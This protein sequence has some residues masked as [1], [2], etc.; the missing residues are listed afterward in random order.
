LRNLKG[1]KQKAEKLVKSH[2]SNASHQKAAVSHKKASTNDTD[3]QDNC[4][5]DSFDMSKDNMYARQKKLNQ[6][7]SF[8]FNAYNKQKNIIGIQTHATCT[9]NYH[10]LTNPNNNANT[11]SGYVAY[12]DASYYQGNSF[13]YQQNYYASPN[14]NYDT[15]NYQGLSTDSD[16]N[17]QDNYMNQYY[18]YDGE[19]Y[20]KN[21]M[22]QNYMPVDGQYNFD[23]QQQNM[24]YYNESA[25]GQGY[26]QYPEYANPSY[27]YDNYQPDY[28]NYG[29][30]SMYQNFQDLEQH[31][32]QSYNNDSCY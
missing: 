19:F 18:N 5:V 4:S 22:S 26:Y 17:Q 14:Q 12:P 9:S 24:N 8:S 21:S 25:N 10:Y 32:S 2:Q 7:K 11:G 29:E 1:S 16:Y 30:Y 3:D 23:Y 15:R 6:N 28:Y 13:D 20:Q 31:Q 27:Q